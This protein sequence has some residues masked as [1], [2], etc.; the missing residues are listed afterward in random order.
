MSRMRL[1][2]GN[3][4]E[5]A[6]RKTEATRR[7]IYLPARGRERRREKGGYSALFNLTWIPAGLA[8]ALMNGREE[9]EERESVYYYTPRRMNGAKSAPS[10]V[11]TRPR[12]RST[13]VR[14]RR[15]SENHSRPTAHA[16]KCTRVLERAGRCF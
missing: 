11:I 2:S 5:C 3:A 7:S 16:Y 13:S 8:P 4:N 6:Q 1:M 15:N 10:R 14:A 12:D 9:E